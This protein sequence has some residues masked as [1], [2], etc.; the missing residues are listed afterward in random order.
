MSAPIEYQF[1]V[2]QANEDRRV[3]VDKEFAGS[4]GELLRMEPGMHV[5]DLGEPKDY[6]PKQKRIGVKGTSEKEPLIIKFTVTP[7]VSKTQ[8]VSKAGVK[9]KIA[10][11][12]VGSFQKAPEIEMNA[13]FREAVDIKQQAV[14][15]PEPG[16]QRPDDATINKAPDIE[17]TSISQGQKFLEE[18]STAADTR[19][20]AQLLES[21]AVALYQADQINRPLDNSTLFMGL[22]AAPETGGEQL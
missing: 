9:K 21:A 13:P 17:E 16:T 15:S 2:V 8:K 18:L 3:Y 1:V 14:N 10:S 5:F 6:K 7:E 4:T 22:L 19:E 20:M 11:G 12:D